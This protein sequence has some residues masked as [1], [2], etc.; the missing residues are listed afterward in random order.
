MAATQVHKSAT[1][2]SDLWADWRLPLM[3]YIRNPGKV[4]DKTMV[5]DELY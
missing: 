1:G 3:E 4:K 5:G 2:G